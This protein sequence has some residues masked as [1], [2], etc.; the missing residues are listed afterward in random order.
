MTHPRSPDAE[1]R[2]YNDVG[3][4]QAHCGVSGRYNWQAVCFRTKK[5]G[6]DTLLG[7]HCGSLMSFVQTVNTAKAQS[8]VE[9]NLARG[10][11]EKAGL[12]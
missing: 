7:R 1:V 2:G 8:G 6:V 12:M 4:T 10:G 9:K 11:Q 5:G 3:N